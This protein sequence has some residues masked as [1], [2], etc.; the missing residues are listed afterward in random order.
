MAGFAPRFEAA[1]LGGL[2][3]KLGLS[4]ERQGDAA[5]A[6]DLLERMA[7]NGA[8]YT[9]TFRLLCDAAAGLAGDAA[10]RK[11]FA[12]PDAYD[13]W[14]VGWRHRLDAEPGSPAARRSAM[15]SVNPAYIPRNHLVEAAL[16][17]AVTRQD[18]SRFEDL[19][20]V[21]SHPYE[22]RPDQAHYAAPPRP[23]ER[24][25]RPSAAPEWFLC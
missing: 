24:V 17:A 14:A 1:H 8:D 12:E 25:L 5:L 20:A 15:R 23:E 13:S 6:K 22:D 21:L 16:Q 9:L 11:L 3:R 2:R 7:A 19:L 18:F 10:V 4:T